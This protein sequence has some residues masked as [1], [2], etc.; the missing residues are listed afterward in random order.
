MITMEMFTKGFYLL[1]F[2][3]TPNSDAHEEHITLPRKEMCVSRHALKKTL[4]EPV[5][6]IL[7]A[8]FPG[9]FQFDNST[10]VRYNEFN[11]NS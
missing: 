3:L 7:Y 5:T 6:G 9:P 4:P 10:N 8:E 11:S 1:G 2:C